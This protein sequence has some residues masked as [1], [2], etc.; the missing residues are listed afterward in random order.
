VLAEELYPYYLSFPKISIDTR[1][2]QSGNLFFCIKGN[3]NGN[4]FAQEALDKGAAYVIM[5]D[6]KSISSIENKSKV[7]EVENSLK[8]LQE[9]ASLHRSKLSIPI[10]G[11]TGSNGKTTTKEL[12]RAVLAERY[13]VFATLGNLNNHIGV[14]LSI[15]SIGE[16]KE[17]AI[18]EM[19][20]NHQKEIEFLCSIARPNYGVI[21]NIGKAHLE[22]FGGV[23][24]IVKGK[25]ELYDYLLKTQGLAFIFNGDARLLMMSPGLEKKLFYGSQGDEYISGLV[26]EE[27]PFLKITWRNQLEPN[28]KYSIKTHLTGDYNLPNIL[29]AISLGS[30]FQMHPEQIN[31]GIENYDPSNHRSQVKNIG[32]NEFILDYYNANPDS[33]RAAIKNLSHHPALQK[34]AILGDMFELGSDSETEHFKMLEYLVQTKLNK[35]LLVGENFYAFRNIFPTLNFMQNIDGASLIV[36]EQKLKNFTILVKGSRGMKLEQLIPAFE[37]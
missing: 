35:N 13:R 14:P 12:V 23:E 32:G 24:G 29:A 8:S 9:L 34:M 26:T 6:P 3:I 1:S 15:L 31:Q 25:K 28:K 7:L 20:A 18:I 37:A 19:G 16:D 27:F 4:L 22:G 2:I 5:D 36:Q 17:I 33:M 21:T 30:F 10:I 11:I